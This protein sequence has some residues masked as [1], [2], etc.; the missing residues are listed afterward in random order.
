ME[1][2][3]EEEAELD[4][5]GTEEVA[6]QERVEADSEEQAEEDEPTSTIDELS[7]RKARSEK[8]KKEPQQ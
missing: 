7:A 1:E 3:A 2:R 5:E 8:P 6:E 4:D